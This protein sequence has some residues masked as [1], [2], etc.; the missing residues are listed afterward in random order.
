MKEITEK[1]VVYEVSGG[2]Y[3][4][5]PYVKQIKDR[6]EEPKPAPEAEID[7]KDLSDANFKKTVLEALGY[8]VIT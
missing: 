5:G 2:N 6:G 7:L 4:R 8:K 3:P 1:G